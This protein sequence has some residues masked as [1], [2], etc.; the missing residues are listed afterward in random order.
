MNATYNSSFMSKRA[1]PLLLIYTLLFAGFTCHMLLVNDAYY[2]TQWSQHL[3]LSYFDG[4]PLIAYIYRLYFTVFGFSDSSVWLFAYT[5]ILLTGF[6]IYRTANL[7]FN[8]RIAFMSLLIWLF[9]PG[10]VR[11]FFLLPTY[12]AA[13]MIFWALSV[14]AFFHLVQTKKIRYYYL[15]GVLLGFLL[16]AKYTG[17]LAVLALLITAVCIKDYRFIYCSKHTYL[18]GLLALLIFSPV[19]IWNIQHHFVSIAFQWHHGY[20]SSVTLHGHAVLLD[21][22]HDLLNYNVFIILFAVLLIRRFNKLKASQAAYA[23]FTISLVPWL[24]FM[25]A[26]LIGGEASVNWSAP[27]YFTAAIVLAY[28]MDGYPRQWALLLMACF[29]GFVLIFIVMVGDKW[30]QY[31]VG[32]QEGW[33][34]VPA[35]NQFIQQ[36]PPE[37]L[38]EKVIYINGDYLPRSVLQR[39]VSSLTSVVSVDEPKKQAF[40]YW[41]A[42]PQVNTP[43]VYLEFLAANESSTAPNTCTRMQ[44]Y[45]YR[46]RHYFKNDYIVWKLTYYRCPAQAFSIS[47]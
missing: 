10:V 41:G 15:T 26:S 5:T 35:M 28:L 44:S 13:Q 17:I 45:H 23:L 47:T 11:F 38:K 36:L 46:L 40:Y 7:M 3:A 42:A 21:L 31:Y 20:G 2:Y 22:L 34:R 32:R 43:V 33:T 8:E 14:C 4:P 18:A 6:A 27:F 24:F 16:L 1:W 37:V 30:P 9:T 12:D 29:I 19:I 25:F 39:S